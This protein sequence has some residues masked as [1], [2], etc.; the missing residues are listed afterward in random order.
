MFNANHAL[1]G[2]VVQ[3]E[4][5]HPAFAA[6]NIDEHVVGKDSVSKDLRERAV[7][8]VRDV[9]GSEVAIAAFLSAGER[10]SVSQVD[11]TVAQPAS[12]VSQHQ[13]IERREP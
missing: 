5:V 12:Y 13:Y 4:V 2:K 7:V 1:A 3:P 11:D 10:A 6:P 9:P 8:A